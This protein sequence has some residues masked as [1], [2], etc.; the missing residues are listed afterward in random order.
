MTAGCVVIG[1]NESARLPAALASVR[2]AGLPMVYVDSGSQDDSV[3][4][5]READAPV[6]QLNPARPFT[7]ARA[8]NEG[9]DALVS[10]HAD[11]AFVMFLD[12]DCQ[13]DP[14]FVRAALATMAATPGCAIVVGVLA[15]E[16]AAPSVYTRMSDLEWSSTGGE[17]IDFGNLGGIMLARIAAIRA[18]GGF[19][20]A[21][22]A[23]EDSELGVRLALSGQCV[24]KIAAPMATHR[25]DITRFGQWWRRSVRAGQALTHRYRLHGQS[26]LHDCKRAYWSTLIWG[27]IVP[28]AAFALAPATSGL[29][30]LAFVAYGALMG[31]MMA[32]YR[33]AGAS[34]G[35]AATAA[36]F[37]TIAKF[38]N[39]V[40]LIRFFVHQSR[41]TTALV[42]YK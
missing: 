35:T 7:A 19:N 18:V 14:N 9:L 3:R 11:V 25:A 12:G 26:R 40:G 4:I 22:I 20:T 10:R 5:A 8:R 17:I 30:L 39:F 2:V 34:V 16:Q 41:G 42:E 33:R 23:G 24:I 37:G 27:G 6:I 13:L 15:E 21:M 29:S 38:A 28:V 36:L 1:R 32:H 31:R